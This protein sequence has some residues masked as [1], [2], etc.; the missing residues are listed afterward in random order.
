MQR[1]SITNRIAA[2]SLAVAVVGAA[3]AAESQQTPPAPGPLRP[4]AFPKVEQFTLGNGLKVI[5]VEKHTLPVV[6]G[7]LI[8]DAGAM[9]EPGTKN[10]LASLTGRLLSEGAAGMSGAEFS[11]R[12][13][14]M[15]AAF[16]A[17]GLFNNSFIDVVAIKNVFP[18]AL[19]LG[20]Q[21]VISPSF[22]ESEFGRVKNMALAAYQQ[23]RAQASGLAADAFIRV[24]FDST[25]PFSRPVAGTTGTIGG[26]TR[27]DVVTWHRSMFAPSAATLLLVGDITVP[28][29]R[30]AA[31]K[32]F[33]A[34][35]ASRAAMGPVANP[36]QK[37]SG[38]RIVLVDRP[39]SVQ[40][41]IIIGQAGFQ[42]TDP[43]YLDMLAL[44]HV[45]GGA[46]SS[47]LN[48]NLRE[49]HGYTYGIF[50]GLDLRA[51]A[52]A[53]NV[54]SEVRTNATDSAL[55]EAINEYR[56]LTT[57][58]VPGTELQGAVNNL[59]ASFPSAV[60]TVQAL[61]GRLQNLIVWGLPLDFYTT[62]RERLAAVTPDDV[63]RV[64][65]SR[66]TPNNLIV[67]VAGD[68]SK[69]EAPIRARNLGAVEVWDANGNKL[70]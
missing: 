46:V 50:S 64:A 12:M 26:L 59:V 43:D 18:D 23:R 32:A 66:L 51:G 17:G 37:H 40:S 27:D 25:A 70:R 15:G 61:T 62:Y 65:T 22:P 57:E 60:Q 45:L 33:G 20:A 39:T 63:R 67:I 4:Y 55:V 5:V 52:G 54:S 34:W 47:R 24:A 36:V 9:R 49:K 6:E 48:T 42:A 10:G 28:E 30:A 56:R 44:N 16:Q 1:A 13:E 68:V 38:T 21:T 11:L 8:I 41:S 2:L 35:T 53:Y 19:A 58:P 3:G 14:S 7:R 31:E 29:A 69:I